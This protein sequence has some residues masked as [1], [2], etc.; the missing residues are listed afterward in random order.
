MNNLGFN[1]YTILNIYYLVIILDNKDKVRI[2][3]KEIKYITINTR[4]WYQ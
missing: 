1:L 4:V 3:D 2:Y